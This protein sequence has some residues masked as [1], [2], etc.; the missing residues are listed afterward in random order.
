MD[1]VFEQGETVEYPNAK[2]PLAL[3]DAEIVMTAMTAACDY[4]R[5]SGWPYR[6]KLEPGAAHL[7]VSGRFQSDKYP[8][9]A[10][11]FVPIKTSDP[12]AQDLLREYAKRRAAVDEDFCA[13]LLAALPRE[14]YENP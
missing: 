10:A 8:W 13:D 6:E 5:E 3:E 11:G 7:T 9:C 12:M 2:K 14:P 1:F 4:V